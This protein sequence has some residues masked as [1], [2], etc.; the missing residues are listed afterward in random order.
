[1]PARV[2]VIVNRCARYLAQDDGLRAVLIAAAGKDAAVHETRT[3]KD[4][5]EAVRTMAARGT[6]RVVLAGGDGSYMAGTSAL[7]RTFGDR[8]PEMAFAPGGTAGTVARNWGL[9]GPAPDYA[10]R[11]VRAAIDGTAK[12]SAHPTLRV[13]DDQGGDRIGFIFGAGLVANFFDAYYASKLQGYPGA[14]AIVARVFA[15]SL[16][17]GALARRVLDPTPCA[18]EVD[19]HRQAPRAWSLVAAS[20]VR[21]L[22]LH[23]ILL[24]RAAEEKSRFHVVASPLRAGRLGPQLPLVLAGKKLLGQGHV[25]TLTADLR[26]RFEGDGAYV[27]DGDRL[28][29]QQVHVTGGPEITLLSSVVGR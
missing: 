24:H 6:D 20:V 14:A 10:S 27:L 7:H 13:H 19:G 12:R 3:L 18:L 5:E 21:N 23:M 22:G 11:I 8:M 26:V 17:G 4:L 25:D 16:Y 2:D 28:R 29:A 1:L 15:G 9:R